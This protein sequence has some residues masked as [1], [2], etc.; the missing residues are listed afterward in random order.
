MAGSG[1]LTD[2]ER[3]I[4]RLLDELEQARTALEASNEEVSRLA[5]DH[6]RLLQRLGT[7]ARELQAAN[8]S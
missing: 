7:Q 1:Q 3:E 2:D 5:E 6:D 4:A 8:T